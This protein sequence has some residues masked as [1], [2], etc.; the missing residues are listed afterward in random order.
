MES[1]LNELRLACNSN[2]KVGNLQHMVGEQA[3]KF[4]TS[5]K[6]DFR[7]LE[8]DQ[9]DEDALQAHFLPNLVQLV[10][11]ITTSDH[12]KYHQVTPHYKDIRELRMWMVIALLCLTMNPNCCFIQT[13]IVLICYAY[14]LRDKGFDVLN[15]L[16]CTCNID[17]LRNHGAFW[18][19]KR[20][21]V[22]EL[23]KTRPW[24]ISI[25]NLN[26]HIK[27][28]KKK[29]LPGSSNGA[30][31]MLNLITGQVTTRTSEYLK[32]ESLTAMVHHTIA[33]LTNLVEP[34]TRLSFQ[35]NFESNAD[36]YYL[37][38]SQSCLATTVKRLQTSPLDCSETFIQSLCKFM[39]HFTPHTRD[40]IVYVTTEE[41]QAATLGDVEGYLIRMKRELCIGQEGFPSKVIMRAINKHFP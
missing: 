22:E 41:A 8:N 5:G 19:N 25:D 21:A 18:A 31:K 15:T 1:E 7:T 35:S 2:L 9:V 16:G 20:K 13:L 6:I 23:D 29:I 28:A 36:M 14:G 30:K 17:H 37:M 11:T 40:A 24:R 34:L 33:K 3:A 12:S 26:F 32:T 27:F 39:P 4:P 10:D 38:F